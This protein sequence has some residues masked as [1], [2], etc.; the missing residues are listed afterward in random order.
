MA[1]PHRVALVTGA[2]RGIGR[3]IALHLAADGIDV[4]VN[5]LP[6]SQ[7]QEVVLEIQKLGRR[8]FAVY[9]DISD[10]AEVEGMVKNV[11]EMFGKLDIVRIVL[12]GS[13]LNRVLNTALP[14]MIAN[15]G[16]WACG[17]I[18]SSALNS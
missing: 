9:A 13:S 4:V 11:V 8:S 3:S 6:G 1:S 12:F 7:A 16:I 17:N 15:A 10:D 2:A 18:L 5:D 14:Q